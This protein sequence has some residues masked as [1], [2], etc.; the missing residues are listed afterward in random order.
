MTKN[1]VEEFYRIIKEA[2]GRNNIPPSEYENFT[3]YFWECYG[4][5]GIFNIDNIAK[6]YK[7]ECKE[8]WE[9]EKKNH[10]WLED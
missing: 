6:D 3:K 8:S 7:K 5:E 2:M 1:P 4:F 10:A 9:E